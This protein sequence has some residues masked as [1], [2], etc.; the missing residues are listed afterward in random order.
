MPTLTANDQIE[1]ILNE[2]EALVLI[3]G[4]PQAQSDKLRELGGYLNPEWNSADRLRRADQWVRQRYRTPSDGR[5][6]QMLTW[7]NAEKRKLSGP[8]KTAFAAMLALVISRR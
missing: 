5:P 2:I 3:Q 1:T 6:Q 8:Q 4:S 7:L